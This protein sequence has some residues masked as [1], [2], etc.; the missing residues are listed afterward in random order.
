M[1]WFLLSP[2]WPNASRVVDYAVFLMLPVILGAGA[3]AVLVSGIVTVA[4]PEN[5]FTRLAHA[6]LACVLAADAALL[7]LYAAGPDSY[8]GG[9]VSRW[10]HAGRF[11]GSGPV[12]ASIVVGAVT[13]LLLAASAWAPDR[14]LLRLLVSPAAAVSCVLLLLVWFW[15]TGGH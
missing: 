11:V 3:V 14:L 5:A 6:G 1:T 7:V 13:S 8:Y 4:K 2:G 10:E 9:G 15:L 12:A